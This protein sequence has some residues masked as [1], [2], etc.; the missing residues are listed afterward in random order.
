MH[1]VPCLKPLAAAVLACA[2]PWA[3][4]ATGAS[5]TSTGVVTVSSTIRVT[6]TTWDGGCKTYAATSA[7]GDGSQDEGQSP[8][9]RVQNGTLRRVILGSNGADGI[10]TYGNVTLDNIRWTDVGEDAM[11]IKEAGTVTVRNITGFKAADKFF[12]VSATSTLNVTNCK[13]N[14]ALKVFRQFGGTTYKT[15]VVLNTCDLSNIREAVFRTDSTSSTASW[16]GGTA[17]AVR[18]LCVGYAAGKCT[19][20]NVSGL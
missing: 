18:T 10:H 15:S 9:F 20:S 1:A 7:L 5:C 8:I 13:I 11:T 14:D 16:V 3:H 2:L 4:A 17:S 6:N 12:Q 19:K